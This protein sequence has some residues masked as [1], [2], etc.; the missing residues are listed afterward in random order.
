MKKKKEENYLEKF[1]EWQNKQYLPGYY[2]GG[3]MNPM[4]VGKTKAGGYFLLF[5]GIITIFTAILYLLFGSDPFE[6]KLF[7]VIGAISL[8]GPAGVLQ[9]L[10]GIKFLHA[11]AKQKNK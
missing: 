8:W 6:P 4:F 1:I 11:H 9:I 10:V 2:V 5:S 3:R 7:S